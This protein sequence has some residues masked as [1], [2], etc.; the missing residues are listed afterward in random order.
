M[1]TSPSTEHAELR[2]RQATVMLQF[3]GRDDVV[4]CLRTDGSV[5]GALEGARLACE[6]VH[7]A[8]LREAGRVETALDVSSRATGVV[9]EA[10]RARRGNDLD[11]IAM[12]RAGSSVMV[13]LDLRPW[14]T[15]ARPPAAKPGTLIPTQAA[16]VSGRVHGEHRGPGGARVGGP[17]GDVR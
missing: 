10:L 6:A 16:R 13:T 3:S 11:G 14:P 4:L 2:G 1:G 17:D 12:R 8:R 9:L 15:V 5:A 7:Q